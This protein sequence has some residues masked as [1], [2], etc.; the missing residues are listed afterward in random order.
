M[1]KNITTSAATIIA[2]NANAILITVNASLTG[3]I[4][5]TAAGST[6]YTTTSSTIATI[7]NPTVGNS[8]SYGGLAQQGAITVTASTTCDITVSVLSKLGN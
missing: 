4:T 7:T 2:S 8:F 1:A 3:S 5:V 6:Q